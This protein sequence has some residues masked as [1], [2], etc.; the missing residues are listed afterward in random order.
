[1]KYF[2]SYSFTKLVDD[3]FSEVKKMATGF[4]CAQIERERPIE[5]IDD[6]TQLA[7][8]IRDNNGYEGCTILFFQKFD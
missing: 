4:N 5:N 2:I 1:M 6:I 8:G 7:V 3:G